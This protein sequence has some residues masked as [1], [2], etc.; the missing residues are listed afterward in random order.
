VFGLKRPPFAELKQALMGVS[1]KGLQ[2]SS[3]W[4]TPASMVF[5]V[6]RLNHASGTGT[7]D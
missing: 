1:L 5:V 4:A 3:S 2:H 7:V 6:N